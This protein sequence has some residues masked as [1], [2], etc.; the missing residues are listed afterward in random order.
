MK[1]LVQAAKFG[2]QWF[3][4]ASATT[5]LGSAD[6]EKFA[7]GCPSGS[8]IE[9]RVRV[10]AERCPES[11]PIS[12]SKVLRVGYNLGEILIGENLRLCFGLGIKSLS[13]RCC[14]AREGKELEG[15]VMLGMRRR[16]G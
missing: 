9:A 13:N 1:L 16:P 12:N 6:W 7:I 4:A 15:G 8:F 11:N 5:Q 10:H 14:R 2:S 3:G